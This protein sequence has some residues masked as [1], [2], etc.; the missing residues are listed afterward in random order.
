MIA[1]FRRFQ[2]RSWSRAVVALALLTLVGC[3]GGGPPRESPPGIDP[4]GSGKAAID[5]YDANHDGVISGPELDQAPA[6]KAALS[7]Y[8][9]NGDGKITAE[10]VAGRIEKWQFTGMAIAN[11]SVAFSL[12]GQKLSGAVIVAE[13]EH[14]LGS[15]IQPATGITDAFGSA[16][17]RIKDKFGANYGLYKIRVSKKVRDKELVPA[18]YNANTELG[19]EFA[20]DSPELSRNGGFSFNLKSK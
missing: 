15:S 10:T 16:D 1:E 17:L 3:A 8:A 18:R 20:P 14:F 11:L 7:R 9:P 6:L 5:E 19:L 2:W 4:A 13:P 12:D